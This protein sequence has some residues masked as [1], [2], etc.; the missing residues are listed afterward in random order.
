VTVVDIR[1]G[2]LRGAALLEVGTPLAL[3]EDPFTGVL[4]YAVRDDA[5]Q[6]HVTVWRRC[7]STDSAL[8]PTP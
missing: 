7:P 4:L 2:A 8:H 5:G 1:T 3:Q 6:R